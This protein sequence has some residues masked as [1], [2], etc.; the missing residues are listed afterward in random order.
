MIPVYRSPGPHFGPP[1]KTY[2]CKGVTEDELAEAI[3]AGWSESFLAA[4]GLEPIKES[5]PTRAEL[6]QKA[7]E[8]GIKIDKRWGDALLLQK[9]TSALES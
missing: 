1:G 6:E 4:I 3:A 8:L 2:D 9:I 7:Q 5:A